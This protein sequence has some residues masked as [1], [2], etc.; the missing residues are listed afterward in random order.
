MVVRLLVSPPSPADLADLPGAP[1]GGTAVAGSVASHPGPLLAALGAVLLIAAGAALVVADRRLPRLRC[2]LLGT[3]RAGGDGPGPGD[4]GGAGRGCRPHRRG[5][6]RRRGPVRRWRV[7]R[8]CLACRG[9]PSREEQARPS[10]EG[11]QRDEPERQ[12]CPRLHRRRCSRGPRRP[13]GA[14]RFRGDQAP[15][16]RRPAAPRRDD[17]PA[18]PGHRGDRG[19]Q[20][21]QPVEGRPRHDPGS[22]GARRGLRRGRRPGDQR[23]HRAAPV[24]RVA[25]RPRRRPR[26][27]GRGDPAQGLRGQPLPGPRGPGVRRGPRAADRRGAGAER[28]D[29]V[30]GPGRVAGHDGAGRGAHRG[31]GRPRPGGRCRPRRGERAQPA[32][33]RG[34]PLGLRPHRPRPA[35]RR[36]AGGRVGRPRA[37][38]PADLRRLGRGCR[39]RRRGPGDQWRPPRGGAGAG[40]R[41]LPPV[42]FQNGRE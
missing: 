28:A 21:A 9:R 34:Q 35:Q 26:P 33:P 23:P 8:Q 4:V 30:A 41:G 12:E 36:A 27:G 16:G 14:G 7:R 13:R 2:P 29:V 15:L 40:G 24:R 39:A 25:G 6:R 17:R 19:G 42:V 18:R 3:S 38:R 20:A 37:G 1:A 11:D 31:G 5:G 22:R 10:G 32:H